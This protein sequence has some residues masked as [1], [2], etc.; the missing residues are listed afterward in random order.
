MKKDLS[1]FL[2][3]LMFCAVISVGCGG[4]SD[5][6]DSEQSEQ[7]TDD[8]GEDISYDPNEEGRGTSGTVTD[9]ATITTEYIARDRETLTGKLGA[10]VKV[11]IAHKATV[12]IKNVTINGV[13]WKICTWAGLN[14]EGD[15]TIILEGSNYIKGFHEYYP[16]IHVTVGK[17]LTI[18]GNGELTTSS[19]R[20]GAGIGCG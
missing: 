11:S 4:G 3:V 16:G 7:F 9:L 20:Y 15:A 8:T 12:T 18:K 13:N 5:S 6:A 2:I 14:C 19:N 1:C 17:T 10:N